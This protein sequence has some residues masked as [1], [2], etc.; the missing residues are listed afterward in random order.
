MTLIGKLLFA[1]LLFCYVLF[2]LIVFKRRGT[3]EAGGDKGSRVVRLGVLLQTLSY[4]V[5][6][7]FR[8]S[9]L[10]PLGEKELWPEI[11]IASV[12]LLLAAGAVVLAAAAKRHLGRQWAL[13][14]RVV[15]GHQLVTDGPFGL[16]RH[17]IY[18][19]MGLLL[20][21]PVI[22]LASWLGVA[23]SVPLFIVG[24]SLRARAEDKLLARTFGREFEEYRCRIPA[25]F[26]RL[27]SR[28]GRPGEE[29]SL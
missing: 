18:A 21:A 19:A 28:R 20:L 7:T 3:A 5:A 26:P 6:W 8:R 17:P 12:S 9:P 24:T 14:A 11:L 1:A 23:V 2:L 16:I 4:P 22:G 13:A 27:G 10:N 29:K 15:N 25:F